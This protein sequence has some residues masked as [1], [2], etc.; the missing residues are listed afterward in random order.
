MR[1]TLRAFAIIVLINSYC[2]SISHGDSVKC[3]WI[4]DKQREHSG[5]CELPFGK[6]ALF[7][8]KGSRHS[9]RKAVRLT[10]FP[11]IRELLG[12]GQR[13]K[14]LGRDWQGLNYRFNTC[15]FNDFEKIIFTI[16]QQSLISP[17]WN[18]DASDIKWG[19]ILTWLSW[20]W[21][22]T[23]DIKF[24]GVILDSRVSRDTTFYTGLT[25]LYFSQ[26]ASVWDGNYCCQHPHFTE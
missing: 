11:F 20:K 22:K 7:R 10:L 19:K 24:P 26:N 2:Y 15:W 25:H 17:M 14:A 23:I 3:W 8:G 18:S 4:Q 9:A 16:T 21:N 6:L 1:K 5:F 12:L 13:G